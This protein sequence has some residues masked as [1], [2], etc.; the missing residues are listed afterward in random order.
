MPVSAC[1]DG[2]ETRCKCSRCKPNQN[3]TSTYYGSLTAEQW[4]R[5]EDTVTASTEP[6]E[7]IL[8]LVHSIKLEV[9]SMTTLTGLLSETIVKPYRFELLTDTPVSGATWYLDV[10]DVLLGT[11]QGSLGRTVRVEGE[12]LPSPPYKNILKVIGIWDA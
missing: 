4:N 6:D 9:G 2:M 1:S 7:P 5:I 12:Q 10:P 8:L 3:T 11:C